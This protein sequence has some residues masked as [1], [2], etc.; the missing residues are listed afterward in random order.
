MLGKPCKQNR[1]RYGSMKVDLMELAPI[2]IQND[3]KGRF[4]GVA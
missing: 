3:H 1:V 2:N 4:N